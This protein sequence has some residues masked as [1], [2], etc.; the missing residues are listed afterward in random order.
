MSG[1][2]HTPTPTHLRARGW[3]RVFVHACEFGDRHGCGCV[4]GRLVRALGLDGAVA[5][6][7]M[8]R[9]HG[10]APL[11]FGVVIESLAALDT[12]G[13]GAGA[14]AFILIHGSSINK[15]DEVKG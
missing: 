5:P 14:D 7:V 12:S 3:V 9:P 1:K 13:W 4:F 11:E 6:H 15:A 8:H 10:D 2:A